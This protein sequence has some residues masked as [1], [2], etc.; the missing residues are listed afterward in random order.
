MEAL[1]YLKFAVLFLAHP[2]R[3]IFDD[4][5]PSG[6][7]IETPWVLATGSI[8]LLLGSLLVLRYVYYA[9]RSPEQPHYSTAAETALLTVIFAVGIS[10]STGF[11][12][13]S[14]FGIMVALSGRYLIAATLFWSALIALLIH[15]QDKK[16]NLIH[17]SMFAVLILVF[18]GLVLSFPQQWKNL[19]KFSRDRQ[20][21]NIATT[22]RLDDNQF[23]VARFYLELSDKVY[24]Y[25][26]A[27]DMSFYRQPW[28]DWIG[29]NIDT[30]NEF[31]LREN[32]SSDCVGEVLT[33]RP[34]NSG[35]AGAYLRGWAW[36]KANNRH[37]D[38]FV[39]TTA[40]GSVEGIAFASTYNSK[41]AKKLAFVKR[42]PFVFAGYSRVNSDAL[43][44]VYGLSEGG[45][46][47]IAMGT[48]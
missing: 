45:L 24:K 7:A 8:G 19:A 27:R 12:R 38:A 4:H 37:F 18:L 22:M 5:L 48:I 44:D 34:L 2:Y 3:N 20:I 6:V 29:R 46:C 43:E 15:L 9:I 35:K 32:G 25:F 21:V 39:F 1:S 47:K 26:E 16:R 30:I 41:Q 28:P 23:G 40:E 17:H 42:S 10:I 33:N 36:D 13:M 11:A 31:A 14:Q